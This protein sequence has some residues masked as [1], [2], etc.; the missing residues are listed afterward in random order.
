M[1]SPSFN[2]FYR[3]EIQVAQYS[4]GGIKNDRLNVRELVT[5]TYNFVNKPLRDAATAS[6]RETYIPILQSIGEITLSA[7]DILPSASVSSISIDDARGS[8]GPD[9]R[10]SDILERFTI[11]DQPLN[12]Y[13]GASETEVDAPTSWQKI[14]GG[15]ILSWSKALSSGEPSMTIQ[16][17]PYKISEKIMNLEVSR[18]ITGMES[19]PQSS[20]GRPLPI[21][22]NKINSDL[23]TPIDRYPQVIPTRISADGLESAK[24]AL[25]TQIYQIT[26]AN[27]QSNYYAKKS[28]A[29]D[30]DVW[31]SISF[32]RTAPDYI[33]PAVGTYY[34]LNTYAGKAYKIPQI[35]PTNEETG[36]VV[37]GVKFSAKGQ[38]VARTSSAYLTAFL[39]LVDKV[40]Y[41]VVQTLGQGRV[42][43]Q[44]YAT[45]NASTSSFSINISFDEPS[46]IELHSAREFDFYIGW[47]ASDVAVNE[48][49]FN[50]HNTTT[51]MLYKSVASNEDQWR[52]GA[53]EQ[54]VAH[55]LIIVSASS[56]GHEAT[57]TKDG[58]TYSSLTLTQP[59][60]DSGQAN[61]AL[62][63]LEIVALVEGFCRYPI[64]VGTTSGTSSTYTATVSKTIASYDEW[65]LFNVTFH[66]R[67]IGSATLNIN[68]LGAK[69]IYNNGSPL[70]G[71]ELIAF[72]ETTLIYNGTYF[73][74]QS[75]KG[76]LYDPPS[77]LSLLS[78]TWD[79]EQWTW[80]GSRWND[81]SVT[82]GLTLKSSHY[83][84][85]FTKNSGNYRARYL[86][87]IIEA[88]S[89]YSQVISEIARGSASKLG[90]LSTG[91]LFIFPWGVT[92]TPA[93][94][95]P[96]ADIIPLSWEARAD[97]SIVNRTQITFEK[98]YATNISQDGA[99]D[100]Y[101]YSIDFSNDD[102]FPVQQ[103][104]E[105]SR[106]LFGARNISENTFN[107][108]GFSDTSPVVG[109]PGYLTGG[110]TASQPTSGGQVIYSVDFLADY[111]ISRFGLPFVYCSFVVP[112]HRY[113]DIKMF[114][115]I[116]FH[117]SEFPA[118]FGTDP[119]AR[120][121]VVDDGLTVSTV[122]NANYGEELVRAKGYRGLVEAVSYVMAMEHAP[123][124]RL[125]VQVLLNTEYDP[126]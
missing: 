5:K 118:Y 23:S 10:F 75:N 17:E 7:G 67:N 1:T 32:T 107:V 8:F 3:V 35:T 85:L 24:Y 104:T 113:K 98:Y 119:A 30:S 63:S 39:L 121:G 124:I 93:Y 16:L 99:R 58:Y 51:Q 40:T 95:I 20:L 87:G 117:H 122:S 109:L 126:T 97:D 18:D 72:S 96:Q 50:K 33:S 100:G 68:G 9:R 92:T 14:G 69:N 112:Y 44:N 82:D 81:T 37:T 6:D 101:K 88:K 78:Y 56:I 79:G 102:Y 2:F 111:Y 89:T 45:Q 21:V 73:E 48:I 114:D 115:V 65:E 36:F 53:S 42:S 80:S 57:Y 76:R 70:V 15:K 28:W 66:I 110:S 74:L 116:S 103:I 41:N 84:K 60:A 108:F 25:T 59:A 29:T 13:I 123:A 43:L 12:I 90:I 34:S 125:T 120:P 86:T 106:S 77:I 11:I 38:G 91:K 55:E 83:D 52:I 46:V 105:Q 54:I 61:C 94:I 47:S 4:L 19:A 49:T 31:A 64:N 22:F 26:K 62:D 27:I 71:S